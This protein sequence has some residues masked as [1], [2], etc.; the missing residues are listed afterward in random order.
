M[1]KQNVA[2]H[3]MEYYT[4]WKR[5]EID[6]TTWVNLENIMLSK[7]HQRQKVAYWFLVF[8][9]VFCFLF[10][11]RAAPVVY[12]GS[13]ARGQIRVTVAGLHHSHSNAGSEPR[14]QP[15]PQLRA[16]PNPNPLSEARD[17]TH[18]LVVPSQICFCC[19]MMGTPKKVAYFM[20]PF[21]WNVQNRQLQRVKK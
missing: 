13:Q 9:F 4:E 7:R 6:A 1:P 16:A 5:N 18:N 15:T 2:I 14:L 11:F 19:T 20:T 10:F 12:R 8:F 21:S 17:Q 3:I